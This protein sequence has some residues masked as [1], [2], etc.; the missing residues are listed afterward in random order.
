[1]EPKRQC[2]H[3]ERRDRRET[4]PGRPP[5]DAGR[6][7]SGVAAS[8]GAPALRAG[9]GAGRRPILTTPGPWVPT[10]ELGVHSCHFKPPHVWRLVTAAPGNQLHQRQ[11]G[12]SRG[13]RGRGW[14]WASAPAPEL[15][16]G[17]GPDVGSASVP[18]SGLRPRVF[19]GADTAGVPVCS[20]RPHA[21]TGRR[22]LTAAA[23][24]PPRD[25]LRLLSPRVTPGTERSP[26]SSLR[27]TP[28]GSQRMR[29]P[30]PHLPGGLA[31]RRDRPRAPR[32]PAGPS[33]SPHGGG[34]SLT[35]TE[36]PLF[37]CCSPAAAITNG[38]KLGGFMVASLTVPGARSPNSV[39]LG[40]NQVSEGPAAPGARGETLLSSC[41][42]RLP[43][44]LG[45]LAGAVTHPEPHRPGQSPSSRSLTQPTCQVPFCRK[46]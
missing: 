45:A 4:P 23:A 44:V 6:A 28:D 18:E 27:P 46:R 15:F 24:T 33:P 34:C 38:H 37:P 31:P 3:Q 19:H 8:Q 14:C 17:T 12:R 10:A 39:S 2:P 32:P 5:E 22:L 26:R 9:G 16:A 41:V 36:L 1:M 21:P 29:P 20:A 43:T 11:P 42:Q 40:Q 25:S 30:A 35:P 13:R 7:R